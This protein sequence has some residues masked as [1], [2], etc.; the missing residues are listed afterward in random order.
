LHELVLLTGSLGIVDEHVVVLLWGEHIVDAE[1]SSWD[2]LGC[3]LLVPGEVLV[4]HVWTV[5]D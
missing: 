2:G 4:D 1:I 5:G 3:G